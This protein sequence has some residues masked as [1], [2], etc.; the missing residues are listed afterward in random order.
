MRLSILF[1]FLLSLSDSVYAQIGGKQL[2][3]FMNMPVTARN[4][5]LGSNFISTID[6]DAGTIWNNPAAAN[7][8]MHNHFIGSYN[9]FISD[10]NGGFGAYVRHFDKLGTFGLSIMYLDYGTFDGY[11]PSGISTG[12]FSAQDQCVN[13]SYGKQLKNNFR[14]GANL[15]YIYSVYESYVSNGLAVDLSAIYEDTANNLLFTAYTR[16]LGYQTIVY[17]STE[18]K[19]LPFEMAVSISKR[20]DHL[21]LRYHLIFQNLQKPDMRYNITETGL[22]DEFG[23]PQIKQMTMGD[24]ILRHIALGGE[25]NLSKHF[26]LRFGYNHQKRKEMTQEQKRG[27]AGFSWGLG[28]RIK[29][30]HL[31]Y[32]SASYFP[33]FN[34]NQFSISANLSEFYSSK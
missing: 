12:T 29:K 4:M 17:N 34:S 11:T 6:D 15:K 19:N 21:P 9:N 26:V 3:G 16:N 30:L 31:S 27:V 10:I 20:L 32:G 8:K 5:A 18:R 33:G 2:F 14:A 24:N 22:K 7:S 1:V 23:N 25:L 13:F 28:F